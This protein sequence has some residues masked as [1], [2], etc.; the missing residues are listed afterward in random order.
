MSTFLCYGAKDFK[1][2]DFEINILP[3]RY[4]G[5][6]ICLSFEYSLIAHK[7]EKILKDFINFLFDNKENLKEYLDIKYNGEIKSGFIPVNHIKFEV[8]YGFNIT[9]KHLKYRK[10][11]INFI[12]DKFGSIEDH[13]EPCGTTVYHEVKLKNTFSL[14]L[15]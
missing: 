9:K 12:K 6:G 10:N 8:G 5:G 4:D 2:K 1:L 7:N 14:N 11:I 15:N 13:N 3:T